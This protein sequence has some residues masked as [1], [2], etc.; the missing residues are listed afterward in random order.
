MSA[1]TCQRPRDRRRRRAVRWA[2]VAKYNS[3][4]RWK[5]LGTC[6]RTGGHP[7]TWTG[8]SRTG[9]GYRPRWIRRRQRKRDRK[10]C[11]AVGCPVRGCRWTGNAVWNFF[12]TRSGSAQRLS[13]CSTGWD[14][15]RALGPWT[16]PTG[17]L[18]GL[19][20]GWTTRARDWDHGT[21]TVSATSSPWRTVSADPP[22]PAR[23]KHRAVAA[24]CPTA[25]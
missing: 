24:G 23:W 15:R 5:G 7:R 14:Y 9:S 4:D 16:R 10:K 12:G 18:P 2:L 25:G 17:L 19:N 1:S 13:C 8:D 6:C 21:C 20:L 11:L 3:S 22:S